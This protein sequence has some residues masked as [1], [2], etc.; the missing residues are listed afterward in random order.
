MFVLVSIMAAIAAGAAV[1]LLGSDDEVEETLAEGE[2]EAGSGAAEDES[3]GTVGEMLI[4][5]GILVGGDGDDVLTGSDDVDDLAGGDGNDTLYGR[6]G[7]DWI[8]GDDAPEATG[9]D[10]LYGGAG[11]D[12]MA[13]NG[14]NDLLE[15]GNGG[16][17]LFGGEGDD[18]LDGGLEDDWLDG[19]VGD[20]LILGGHGSDDLSGGQGNDT[21]HGGTGADYLHGGAGDDRLYGG[22]GDWLDGNEGDDVFTILDQE[23]GI[24]HVTDFSEGDRIEIAVDDPDKAILTVTH[25]I[26]GSATVLVNDEPVV[27]VLDGI[28][29][30]AADVALVHS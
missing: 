2:A 11:A 12:T 14:G 8:F 28:G 16:D 15:G 27:L 5:R 23:D 13:G 6:G 7:D 17:R 25:D 30:L 29:L 26:D 9:D 4:G 21:L 19:G 3:S 1:D 20:D 24:A 22:A 10:L 18:T